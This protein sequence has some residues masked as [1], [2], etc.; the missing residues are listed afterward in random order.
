MKLP[1]IKLSQSNEVLYW[2][3]AL[4]IPLI[5]LVFAFNIRSFIA[6]PHYIPSASMKPTI[7]IGD[8]VVVSKI[9]SKLK[10][11]QRMEIVVLKPTSYLLK[12]NVYGV[13]IKRVI[14]LPGEKVQVKNGQV[15]VNG[16]PL[17]EKYLAEKPKYSWGPKTIPP[18]SYLVLGDNRN[19]SFDGHNWGFVPIQNIVG[20]AIVRFWPLDSLDSF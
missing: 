13:L 6:E 12:M 14:G 2:Y 17:E 8:R 15:Y 1:K 11:P 9:H 10:P 16:K 19:Q 5:G 3:K 20:R 18:N 7:Q 4:K